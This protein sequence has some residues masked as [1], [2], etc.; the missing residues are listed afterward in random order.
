MS[1]MI[2]DEQTPAPT[3]TA[4]AK[5]RGGR[6]KKNAIA[7]TLKETLRQIDKLCEQDHPSNAKGRLL[8]SKLEFYTAEQKFQREQKQNRTEL[9]QARIQITLD[10]MEIELLKKKIEELK[11]TL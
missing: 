6:P 4:P 1:D 8:Q 11:G 10:R 3:P 9:E 5:N 2:P 7:D